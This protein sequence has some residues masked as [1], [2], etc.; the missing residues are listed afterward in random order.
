MSLIES[1]SG[2]LVAKNPTLAQIQIGGIT[3]NLS[4][5]ISTFE[6][7]PELDQPVNLLTHLHVKEDILNLFGFESTSERALFL[8]L[9]TISGIGPKS[10][11][12]ILSGTTPSEF[13]KKIINSDVKSLTSIPGIGAKTAKRIIVELKE[14]FSMVDDIDEGLGFSDQSDSL[15]I[16][17]A[18]NALKSLGYKTSQISKA[19]SDINKEGKS[20]DKL[21]DIIREALKRM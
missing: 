8:N 5:S 1:V 3:Y 2:I 10:A 19:F 6:K 12:S 16:K 15:V 14:K 9:N 17:D 4:I 11:M 7:L 21:E 13:R 20:I 18:K